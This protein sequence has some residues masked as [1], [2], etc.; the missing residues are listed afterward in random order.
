M[1]NDRSTVTTLGPVAAGESARAAKGSTVWARASQD[2]M[3]IG[4]VTPAFHH[5][6]TFIQSRGLGQEVIAVQAGNIQRYQFPLCIEPGPRADSV[7]G[8]HG[9]RGNGRCHGCNFSGAEVGAPCALACAGSGGEFLAMRVSARKAAKVC[10]LAQADTGN[11]KAHRARRW[12]GGAR[13]Q[14][15]DCGGR[16]AGKSKSL[17]FL[18]HDSI[19]V[20]GAGGKMPPCGQY[21]I[22]IHAVQLAQAPVAIDTEFQAAQGRRSPCRCDLPLRQLTTLKNRLDNCLHLKG[23]LDG[24]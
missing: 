19:P 8:M 17:R 20:E 6:A 5:G 14:E 18:T 13:T 10:A 11:K 22:S 21:V 12:R 16:Q 2:V 15:G 24:C 4:R 7:A 1:A 23:F 9:S 3:L